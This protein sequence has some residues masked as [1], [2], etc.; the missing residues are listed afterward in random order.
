MRCDVRTGIMDAAGKHAEKPSVHIRDK[1]DLLMR[2][3]AAHIFAGGG[4]QCD[5]AVFKQGAARGNCLATPPVLSTMAACRRMTGRPGYNPARMRPGRIRKCP[6]AQIF[7]DGV[8]RHTQFARK[9]PSAK[10]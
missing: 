5:E 10:I 9:P 8:F 1:S 7:A 3:R 2:D 6:A 4:K